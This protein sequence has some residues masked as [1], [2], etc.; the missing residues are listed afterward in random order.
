MTKLFL[1]ILVILINISCL[2]QSESIKK[3]LNNIN[4][5]NLEEINDIYYLNNKKY[6]GKVKVFSDIDE[7]TLISEYYLI[8][9]ILNG[10]LKSFNQDGYL[11]HIFY[12][13]EN[14]LLP[15]FKEFSSDFRLKSEIKQLQNNKIK[16]IFYQD[17]EFPA[18]SYEAIFKFEKYLAPS[19]IYDFKRNRLKKCIFHKDGVLKI[20]NKNGKIRKKIIY[21]NNQIVKKIKFLN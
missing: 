16:V 14:Y 8:N 1:L 3:T 13:K 15:I 10:P 5:K 9:G 17:N 19:E 21:E 18:M 7:K 2:K 11:Q 6:S 20:F 12:Y 4:S